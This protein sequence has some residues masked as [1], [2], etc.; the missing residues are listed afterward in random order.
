MEI[1]RSN[2]L[3][4]AQTEIFSAYLVRSGIHPDSES[5]QH[6]FSEI[7]NEKM[8]TFKENKLKLTDG[9]EII[10]TT[11]LLD[12][13]AFKRNPSMMEGQADIE[14]FEHLAAL[15]F[16]Q[17]SYWDSANSTLIKSGVFV[18]KGIVNK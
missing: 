14:T 12:N 11:L 18:G 16:E 10:T 5:A 1:N 9:A 15:G 13:G 4:D 2:E 6:L 8:S 7:S 3:T 17:V